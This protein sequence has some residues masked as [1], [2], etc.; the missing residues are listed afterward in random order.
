MFTSKKQTKN[1]LF[2][3]YGPAETIHY[4]NNTDLNM[5]HHNTKTFQHN[6]PK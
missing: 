1:K 5:E 3:Q 2:Q 6:G 4:L